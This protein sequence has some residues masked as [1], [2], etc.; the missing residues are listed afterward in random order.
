MF[1]EIQGFPEYY[2]SDTGKVKH[3]DT[4][5]T[6]GRFNTGYARVVLSNNGKPFSKTIHR[7]VA[8][9]FLP[10]PEN[11]PQVNHKDG[12]KL[13]NNV[14]N[15]EWVTGSENIQH[16]LRTG[17]LSKFNNFKVQCVETG[18]VFHSCTAAGIAC[19]GTDGNV[20]ARHLKGNLKSAYKKHWVS[21]E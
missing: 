15:L 19:G 11:K 13:N 21:A 14:E 10:N 9:A 20:I 1:K 2:I 7:L 8:E 17:L 12:N 6:I 18:E 4:F 5:L 16:A 3:G